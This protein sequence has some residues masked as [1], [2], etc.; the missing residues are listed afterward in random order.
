MSNIP[1]ESLM[2]VTLVLLWAALALCHEKCCPHC[3]R[4]E[5]DC[6]CHWH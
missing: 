5:S 3:G 2:L 1:V 6:I 4:P